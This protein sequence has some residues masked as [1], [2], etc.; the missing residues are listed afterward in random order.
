[1]KRENFTVARVD[2]FCCDQNKKQTIYWDAKAPG[3]G[4]RVTSAGARAYVFESRLFGKT[5]RLTIGDPRTWDLA[6]A[7][8]E[9]ARMKALVNEGKD[10]R[11]LRAEQRVAYEA[12]ERKKRQQVVTMGEVWDQYVGARKAQWSERTYRDHVRHSAVGGRAKLRGKGVTKPGVLASLRAVPMVELTAR[13]VSEWLEVETQVRPT[14]ASL[15]YRMLRAFVRWT[16]DEPEYAGL[17]SSDAY[18]GRTVRKLVPRSSAKHGDVLQRE[19]LSG[20]F[21]AVQSIPNRVLSV[22]LQGL[23]ITGARREELAALRWEDVDFQWRSLKIA[24]KVEKVGGRTI[25]LTPYLAE[26]LAELRE[27]ANESDAKCLS[28]EAGSSPWVFRSQRSA[29]GY[30]SDPGVA[31]R[32]ALRHAGLPHVTLHGLRR[33]F[34]TLSE[35][36]DVPVGVVAQIQGHKPSAIAEKHYRRRPLDLLRMWHDKIEAWML[37][38]GGLRSSR[39]RSSWAQTAGGH[40]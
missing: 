4:L 36:I 24:D 20:W 35:W 15:G 31:H 30:V 39:G 13:R 25:P 22:Y 6:A 2:A 10:P 11:V 3:L 21:A 37:E 40:A 26:L 23:L 8:S 19:Q 1:M 18:S 29:T 16:A 27:L 33:S 7:R 5:V 34:G 28:N 9:A 17:V 32:L 12:Q 38:Q 14:V